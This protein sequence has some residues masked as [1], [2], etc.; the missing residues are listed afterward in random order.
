MT[1]FRR[2]EGLAVPMRQ[3]NID[4]GLLAHSQYCRDHPDDLRGGLFRDWR[5]GDDG[6]PVADFILDRPRYAGAAAIVAGPN[7][8]CGSS[9][10]TAVWALM[11]SGF[12]CVVASSFGDIFRDNCYQNG[13]LPVVLPPA[14]IERLMEALEQAGRP[15]LS[16]DLGAQTV[17]GPGMEP[18]HFDI[19]PDRREALME[20]LDETLLLGRS[21]AA[22]ARFEAADRQARPW[23]Y[24]RPE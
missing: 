14:Q 18:L 4:T 5:F 10:E 23:I 12:R 13:L 24:K 21:E 15:E 17:T 20:G 8:G 16:V 2:L 7:F 19:P 22:F 9:R 3:A 11:Q 6:R 1:P